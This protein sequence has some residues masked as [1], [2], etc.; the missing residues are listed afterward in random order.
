METVPKNVKIGGALGLL[1]GVVAV[2]CMAV[3]FEAEESALMK[4]GACMLTAVMFFALAGGFAKG[5]Q[6]SWNVLLLMTFLTI[7]AAGSSVI[8]GA[9]DLYVGVILVVIGV[10]I[11]ANLAVPA[12]KN[13][14]DRIRI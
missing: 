12:S 10:L 6:W 7:G 14:A 4:M 13:W 2:V 9:I 8:L 1:G 11:V 5:G 3:F